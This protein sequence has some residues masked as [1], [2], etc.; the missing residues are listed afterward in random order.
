M[1]STYLTTLLTWSQL[2]TLLKLNSDRLTTS[3]Q[4]LTNLLAKWKIDFIA[5]SHGLF[6]FAR[7]AKSAKSAA[8]EEKFYD[9]LAMAGV[10]V[11]EGKLYK[12]VEGE[13]GWARIRFSLPVDVLQ[14]A[15][16]RIEAVLA[17]GA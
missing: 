10:R 6:V 16:G 4:L 7:L 8:D 14:T 3:C 15:I 5:P 11:G 12:G 17:E 1:A 9:K 13:Y 2:P